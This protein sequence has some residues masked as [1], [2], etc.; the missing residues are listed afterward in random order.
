MAAGWPPYLRGVRAA[1]TLLTRL[2][3]G[4]FPYS[5]ADWRWSA[6]YLPLVGAFLG[7]V[8]G[9]VWLLTV[10]AGPAVA[11]VVVLA[12]SLLLTGAMHE[13]GLADTAD[14]LGGATTRERMF[15]ILKDS[16]IGTFGSA[17]LAVSLLL[18]A[19]LL[20]RLAEIAPIVLVFANAGARLVPVWLMA[21]L[22]YVTDAAVAKS[23]A[24]AAAGRVQVAVAT[25]IFGA[26]A[27]GVCMMHAL[28]A[29]ELGAA[30]VSVVLAG[31]LCAARFRARAGGITGDFLGA[32]EQVSEC[33][34]LLAVAVARG[35]AS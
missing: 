34:L 35:G 18:R 17:A 9:G 10:R 11:A 22:P 33:V 27:C 19:A 20:A 23:S 2:P 7:A 28:S 26:L 14:A 6:A 12:M 13:D 21:A 31:W 24:I 30:L 29:V 3:V 25:V 32:A 1:V 5:E 16:R 4:G 8:L 15:A